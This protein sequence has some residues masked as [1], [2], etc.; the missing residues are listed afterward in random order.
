MTG[1]RT[2]FAQLLAAAGWLFGA[3]PEIIVSEARSPRL[4]RARFAAAYAAL[5]GGE[6]TQAHIARAMN[7]DE[8]TVRYW[9]AEATKLRLD[10]PVFREKSDRLVHLARRRVS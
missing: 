3:T 8:A 10:D 5:H 6:R 2:T 9:I 1:G 7:R 4:S